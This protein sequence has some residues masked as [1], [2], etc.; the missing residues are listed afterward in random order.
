M[1]MTK[2]YPALLKSREAAEI[3]NCS[4]RTIP[5]LC[6]NGTLKAV[7]V[8]YEWRINRDALLKF[9]GLD[10]SEVTACDE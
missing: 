2:R 8:G 5:R 4:T 6:E 1:T 3:L 7:K 9:A 10:E